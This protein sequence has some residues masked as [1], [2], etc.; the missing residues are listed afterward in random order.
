MTTLRYETTCNCG[1]SV[2]IEIGSDRHFTFVDRVTAWEAIHGPHL[3]PP[4]ALP[5]HFGEWRVSTPQTPGAQRGETTS[6]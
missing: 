1:T 4:A 3:K 2:L 6:P 5:G